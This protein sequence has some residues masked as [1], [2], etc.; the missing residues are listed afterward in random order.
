M[1]YF[2]FI[3]ALLVSYDYTNASTL[4]TDHSEYDIGDTVL[5]TGANG[6]NYVFL[7]RELS[8]SL[9]LCYV[10]PGASGNINSDCT[11]G[12]ANFDP[13][14]PDT[15][16]FV[17]AP[18]AGCQT[19]DL[20]TCLFNNSGDPDGQE[21][22]FQICNGLPCSGGGGGGT[23]TTASSTTVDN[24]TQD[25]FNGFILFYIVFGGVVWFFRRK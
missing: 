10:N 19:D 13:T 16:H 23:T 6:T 22:I 15:Y 1:K 2:L 7:Y 5:W 18:V 20:A 4:V 21:A 17:Q 24:P 25:L 3:L 12:A 14:I 11:L 8:D 9:P